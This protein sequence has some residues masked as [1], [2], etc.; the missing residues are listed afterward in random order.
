MWFNRTRD[1]FSF[2][3]TISKIPLL[4]SLFHVG[5]LP[6]P[7]NFTTAVFYCINHKFWVFNPAN[8]IWENIQRFGRLLRKSSEMK[9]FTTW[10]NECNRRIF[11]NAKNKPGK[12]ESNLLPA[13]QLNCELCVNTW[14]NI[15]SMKNEVSIF[16]LLFVG[17]EWVMLI[18]FLVQ[19]D[20]FANRI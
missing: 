2:F 5:N 3:L 18:D 9:R 10:N 16:I 6:F 1:L 13:T 12:V 7:F 8:K 20:I 14:I 15:F 11:E 4:H 17:K 19:F